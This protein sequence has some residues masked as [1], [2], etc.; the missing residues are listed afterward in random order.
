MAKKKYYAVR[1]G[2]SRGIF[3]TWAE[4]QASVTGYSNAIYKSFYSLDEARQ[5]L[6]SGTAPAAPSPDATTDFHLAPH[7]I[8]AYVDGSY[9]DSLQKYS[10]GCVLITPDGEIIEKSGNG[11]NPDSLAIRNVAGEMIGAM[12]AVRWA[13]V[14]GYK[15][16]EIRYDYAG[17]EN[18]VTG[19]W[20][21]KNELTAKYAASMNR[22]QQSI[23]IAFCKV[24]AHSN[25]YYNDEA[26]RL[27]KEALTSGNGIPPL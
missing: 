8:I 17:I 1:S 10:F 7:E 18:W 5:Y 26:D 4:C 20:Q 25:D 6:E 11:N 16:I 22:W 9:Q 24:T 21:A 27:A 13:M 15:K 12:F 3:H 19:A 23:T 14:N 2:K